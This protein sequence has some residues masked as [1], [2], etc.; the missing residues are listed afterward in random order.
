MTFGEPRAGD[1]SFATLVNQ[2]TI[3][4]TRINHGRDI[5]PHLPPCCGEFVHSTCS[6]R[7]TCPHHYGTEVWYPAGM[8]P[9]D[10]SYRVCTS[11]GEDP[12]C[13]NGLLTTLDVRDHLY[14]FNNQ[15]ASCCRA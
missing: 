12:Q 3:R 9:G 4:P 8:E 2:N 11:Q 5:V 13:S 15:L 7:K 14:Y 1:I 10:D 6:T